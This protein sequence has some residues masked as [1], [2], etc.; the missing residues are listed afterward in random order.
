MFTCLDYLAYC[1]GPALV[2]WAR[3]LDSVAM[4]AEPTVSKETGQAYSRGRMVVPFAW[5]TSRINDENRDSVLIRTRDWADDQSA[6]L[7]MLKVV[8]LSILSNPQ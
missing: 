1:Y 7:L 5:I 6:T 8:Y 3:C 4:L 2:T